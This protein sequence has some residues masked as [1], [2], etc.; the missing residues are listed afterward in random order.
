VFVQL[1]YQL[2]VLVN[3]WFVGTIFGLILGAEKALL[4]HEADR[5]LSEHYIR[6]EARMDLA[7]RGIIATETEIRKWKKE[8][9][10]DSFS[11]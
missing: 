7:R 4:A 2:L 10:K 9:E 11:T 1:S 8:K 5:R 3:H 6:K